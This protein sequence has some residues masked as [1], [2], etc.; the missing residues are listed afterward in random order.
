MMRDRNRHN[1]PAAQYLRTSDDE[2][3][4]SL[5]HQ[6]EAIAHYAKAHG[7]T[8]I[9]TYQDKGKS[10]LS[11]H[12]R[13]G[14]RSLLQD[15]TGSSMLF[16][17][18]LVYDVSRWGRFQDCDESAH[19]EFLCKQAGAPIHYCA[20]QFGNDGTVQSSL[21]KA[22]KRTMAAEFS[23]ELS[24]RCVKGKR[25]S[26]LAGLACGCPGYAFRRMAVSPDG[27]RRVELFPGQR[28]PFP[29]DRTV[30]VP[31]PKQ[32]IAV[33]RQI[34]TTFV[35]AQ[36]KLGCLDIARQ[37]NRRFIPASHGG[38]WT[39]ESVRGIL[40]NPKYV[41]KVIWGRTRKRLQ[42]AVQRQ[43]ESEWVV[44]EADFEQMID[45]Q[46]FAQ[47]QAVLVRRADRRARKDDLIC[48]LKKLLSEHGYL[49]ESLINRSAGHAYCTYL[50][51][52]GS[53]QA[54]YETVGFRF[55]AR[56]FSAI[57]RMHATVHLKNSVMQQV[58][59]L[60][61]HRISLVR[62]G[63]RSTRF[64][65]QLDRQYG[66]YVWTACQYKTGKLGHS[67]WKL[68][69]HEKEADG[70]ALL[71]L[72]DE[73]NEDWQ[74]LFLLPAVKLLDRQYC[75]G[76]DDELLSAGLRLSELSELCWAAREVLVANAPPVPHISIGDSH[77]RRSHRTKLQRSIASA[78]G[79][80]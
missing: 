10:G 74:F 69:R 8:V 2:Q 52:F 32:E 59:L 72:L 53:L 50:R 18:I 62:T 1:V 48:G 47:A 63:A 12:N 26:A 17:A 44:R 67:R 75:F 73:T 16:R 24:E 3:R 22:L 68:R 55:P 46:T 42:N 70:L 4:Y 76:I 13:V 41:G 25:R 23:R 77:A 19:Y 61:P 38:L 56:T 33:V 40:R 6:Q 66:I 9:K 58:Q 65:L 36:G 37:L 60:F 78:S 14:L 64:H 21:L 7:F 51:W 29:A 15:L 71:C 5:I 57:Q 27:K 28:P 20:E 11:A 45:R 34:F 49:S 80:P 79:S 43:P 54:A 39:Y 35:R 31:G 30:L